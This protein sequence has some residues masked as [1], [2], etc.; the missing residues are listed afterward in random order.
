MLRY[1]AKR[2]ARSAISVGLPTESA[3]DDKRIPV[4]ANGY[5][6]TEYNVGKQ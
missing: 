2:W 6:D 1:L 3:E 4:G 5:D